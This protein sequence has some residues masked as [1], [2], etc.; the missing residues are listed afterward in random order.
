MSISTVSTRGQLVIPQ[1][2]RKKYNI[3]PQS[4]VR[5]IDTGEVLILVPMTSDPITSSRGMLK[6]TKVST[7]SYLKEKKEEKS[8][9]QRKLRRGE[10]NA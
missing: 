1:K 8:L 5:W 9:E 2:I 7:Y 3:N 10:K 4:S 6:G